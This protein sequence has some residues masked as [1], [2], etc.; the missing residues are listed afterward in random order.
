MAKRIAYFLLAVIGALL[1]VTARTR[2]ELPPRDTTP[3]QLPEFSTSVP[4]RAGNQTVVL[5]I[6]D[7]LGPSI[8]R[9]AKMPNLARMASQGAHTLDMMPVF[10]SLSMPNHFALST[11]CYPEHH[12][13]VSNHFLEPERGVYDHRGDA[14][15]LLGCQPLHVVAEGQGVRAAVFGHV[16]GA[17]SSKG[18]LATVAEPFEEPPPSAAAQADRII[19]QLQQPLERRTRL[20]T[21]YVTEPDEAGHKYGPSAP[22]TI[23]MAEAIDVQ[24]GRVMAEVEKTWDTEPTTLIVTSDHGMVDAAQRVSVERM[25]HKAGIGATVLAEG[26]LA[27]V[28]LDRASDKAAAHAALSTYAFVDV[29]DPQHAP[30]HL[31]IT[32][33]AGA[34]YG[35]LIVSL[36]QGAWTVDSAFFPWYLRWSNWVGDA[37]APST[38]FKG[39]HGYDPEVVPD[40]RAIFYAFGSA[41]AP[42][43]IPNMRTI[44]VHPTVALLLGI[45]PG[46]PVDGEAHA[47]IVRAPAP[48]T[49][50]EVE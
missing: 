5:F 18:K 9:G 34:R 40:V 14:D 48:P 7:G 2:Y 38:R 12:G 41:I 39:M 44:D 15:W 23:A 21:A 16:A 31:H 37:I 3:Q 27:H 25:L 22:E 24:I 13:V 19:E 33:A 11:G 46:T 49:A 10:P 17:S 50:P 6:F 43:A 36:H 30:P 28:Y 26:S 35:D 4:R 29:I 32:G 20:I 47:E 8:V 42:I 45:Q 1:A